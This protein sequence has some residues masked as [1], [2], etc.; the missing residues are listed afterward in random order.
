MLEST[1]S[2][3]CVDAAYGGRPVL[4]GVSLEVH[5]GEVVAL[6][7][8]NGSGKSS[9]LKVVAGLLGV[10]SGRVLLGGEVLS[11]RPPHEVRNLGVSLL[12]Q[13]GRVF[14]H[15]SVEENLD[16][17]GHQSDEEFLFPSLGCLLPKRA[18]TLSGGQRQMLAV[19]MALARHPR[20]LLLDEPTAGLAPDV[21]REFLGRLAARARDGGG[22]V[23]LAEQNAT[24]ALRVATRAIRL[25][26]GRVALEEGVGGRS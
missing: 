7:G 5:Q 13:G 24:E 15:L 19:Q 16:V 8:A 6:L 14:D 9:T 22:A 1:L 12:L 26:N 23:L 20:L 4:E 21:A 3:D 2:L 18:G 11:G 10:T 25:L 17:A